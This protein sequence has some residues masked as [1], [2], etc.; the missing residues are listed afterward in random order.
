MLVTTSSFSPDATA[1]QQRHK[2]KLALRDYGNVVEW[3]NDYKT[4][5][6]RI[7]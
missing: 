7:S 3:I 4:G 6:N 2:Y 5:K 1:F